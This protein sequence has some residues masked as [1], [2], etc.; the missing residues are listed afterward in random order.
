M[1]GDNKL[2][3]D[4]QSA[5]PLEVMM[6]G[7]IYVEMSLS[8][9]LTTVKPTYTAK[10]VMGV[11]LARCILHLFEGPW[12]QGCMSIDDIYVYCRIENDQPHPIFDKVFVATRFGKPGNEGGATTGTY[13]IHPFP[14]ILALGIILIELELGEDLS[15]IKKHSM[16]TSK[17]GQPFYLARYL[18]KEFQKHFTLDSGL[19]RAVKFCIDRASFSRFDTLDSNSLLL[20]QEFIDIYYENIVRPLEQDL[21]RG[22]HWT[23]DQVDELRPPS[24]DTGVCKIF[25]S[26]TF[27]PMH[28]MIT[29]RASLHLAKSPS[30]SAK[31]SFNKR[32]ISASD[33][34]EEEWSHLDTIEEAERRHSYDSLSHSSVSHVEDRR[35]IHGQPDTVLENNPTR[36]QSRADFHIAIICALPT[37]ANAV[38]SIF[39]RHWD[40]E[41]IYQY[42]KQAKD[43][44]S[45]STGSIG[46]HNVVLAHQPRMGKATAANVAA[47]CSMSFPNINLALVV[48]VCGGVPFPGTKK[49]ILLGDVVISKGIVQ[50][51][52]GRRYPDGFRP[53]VT[54]DDQPGRPNR[55]I[56]SLMARLELNMQRLSLQQ[57][58][59]KYLDELDCATS[60]P[61]GDFYPGHLRDRLFDAEYVHKHQLGS[62][63]MCKTSVCNLAMQST[64][65]DLKCGEHRL[66]GRLRQNERNRPSLHFGLM[67]SGDTVLKSAIE[68]DR[69]AKEV[70]VI[71]FEMEGSGV[72]ETMP[73]VIIKGVC[74][75]A[76][77]H[78]N[79]EWHDYAATT[80]AASSKAFL[81]HWSVGIQS[82]KS[83]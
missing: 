54:I 60:K 52:F 48:G 61:A 47:A 38:Q 16:F 20:N 44:N 30:N 22:A 80:A 19:I 70:N 41:G 77:S 15:D 25:T 73:C 66:I 53:K 17:K 14:T 62:C 37:E 11:T 74:D 27:S 69:I 31:L 4:H 83:I 2:W 21:V 75:Y 33:V 57:D 76:D 23:W 28:S 39:D 18:L 55:E 81:R 82:R 79:K 50:Y 34:I 13:K 35:G 78:K 68:R 36:P 42:G 1:D 63:N 26:K 12:L 56:S 7:E 59:A 6:E 10:R 3:N 64:C 24:T 43:P 9:L 49:E 72:W 32:S 8:E 29:D 67:G 45:Y 58:L 5:Q 51:D 65:Q 40:T 71:A 46:N